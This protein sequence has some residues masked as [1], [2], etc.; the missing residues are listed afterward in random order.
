MDHPNYSR[1]LSVHVKDL[2][3]L[4][5][6]APAIYRTFL[7]GDFAICKIHRPF[8]ATGIDQAHQE[9]TLLPKV[10]EV[11]SDLLKTMMPYVD[12]S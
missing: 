10:M 5:A 7:T 11:L 12:A 6:T 2:V 8:S 9:K 1:W 3:E 4:E